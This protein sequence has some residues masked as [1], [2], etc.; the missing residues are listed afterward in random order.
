MS[1]PIPR[2]KLR[3]YA[4]KAVTGLMYFALMKSPDPEKAKLLE[5]L[6]ELRI[7]VQDI[8]DKLVPDWAEGG[9]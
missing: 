7:E 4:K 9:P 3:E 5:R 2:E 8:I 1:R 6:T